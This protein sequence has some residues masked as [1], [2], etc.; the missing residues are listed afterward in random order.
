M[1]ASTAADVVRGHYAAIRNRDLPGILSTLSDGI[2]WEFSGPPTIPFAGKRSGID[3]VA[4]FF[5]IIRDTVDVIEFG[6]DEIVEQHSTVVA[7]G[8]E[9]FRVKATGREWST[10]WAQVHTV[11][12]GKICE[13]R[14][15]ADTAAINA[16]YASG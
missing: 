6:I 7:I 3:A 14:E 4:Q 5:A 8:H 15:Y 1:N 16:A 12:D 13:F 10:R 9:R 11:R 2:A